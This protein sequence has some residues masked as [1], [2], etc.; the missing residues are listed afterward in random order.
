M[1][2]SGI[3]RQAKT[4]VTA[5]AKEGA[6]A[7]TPARGPAGQKTDGLEAVAARYRQVL[8]GLNAFRRVGEILAETFEID[9]ICERAVRIFVEELGFENASILLLAEDGKTLKLKAAAG[10]G[11]AGLSP[12]ERKKLNR[13]LTMKVGEGVAG[14]VVATGKMILVPDVSK[15]DVFSARE[16]AVTVRSLLCLP[17]VAKTRPVGAMN[18]SHPEIEEVSQNLKEVLQVLS[19]MV[20]QVVTIARLSSDLFR[21]KMVRSERL[22]GVGQLAASVVHEINNPLTNIMLRAQKI[23]LDGAAPEGTRKTAEEIEEAGK[24]ISRIV[25]RLLD[26]TRSRESSRE[27]MNVHAVLEEALAMTQSFVSSCGGI[28]VI[29]EFSDPETFPQIVADTGCLEQVFTNLVI[30]A[31]LALKDRGRGTITVRT[32]ALADGVAIEIE[33]DGVGIPSENVEKI[34]EPFFTT[35]SESDGTGLGLFVCR[36]IVHDHGGTVTVRSKPGEGS[37]FRI[38][39]PFGSKKDG[40]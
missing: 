13:G 12:D 36:D 32:E 3:R 17:V 30:N 15:S 14:Q 4:D 20:G 34:F 8:A 37:R 22:A 11:D 5:S 1:P 27:P 26:Y 7:R 28:R 40:D 24:K 21:A 18:L 2:R 6:E 9:E 10:R 25:N 39:L 23:E 38:A 31:A 33:D 29:R 35:R 16:T 19:S